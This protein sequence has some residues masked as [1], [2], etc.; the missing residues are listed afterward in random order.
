[1]AKIFAKKFTHLSP[2]WLQIRLNEDDE[3]TRIEGIHDIDFNWMKQIRELNPDIKIIPRIIFDEWDGAQLMHLVVNP[4]LPGVIG[5]QMVDLAKKYE[6]DGFVLEVWNMFGTSQKES[7]I[8]VLSKMYA[9]FKKAKILL[10]L[11]VPPPIH[12]GGRDGLFL[13]DDVE[14]LAPYVHGFSVM[15]YDYSNSQRPGPNSPLKWVRECIKALAPRSTSPIRKKLFIGMN[16]YGN[17]Y[18]P[19]GGGPIIGSQ[20]MEI[21]EKFKPKFHWDEK[22]AEHYFEYKAGPGRNRVFYP[23]LYS[24]KLR[25]DLMEELGASISL[26][27]LGQG[28]DYF[29]DLF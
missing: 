3:T 1:M 13:K 21:L 4:K 20:Y 2:V 17:D 6:L 23:T 18:T 7:A 28:L 19:S 22:N 25:I 29:Y 5:R 27:E 16:L 14:R 10:F 8:H 12:Y 11:A 24:M 15:T 9:H 26:W